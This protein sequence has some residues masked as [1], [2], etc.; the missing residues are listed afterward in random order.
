MRRVIKYYRVRCTLNLVDI[1]LCFNIHIS[2]IIIIIIIIIISSGC[3]KIHLGASGVWA[4]HVSEGPPTC[5]NGKL[6]RFIYSAKSRGCCSGL[7]PLPLDPP[8]MMTVMV[9]V[10]TEYNSS[11]VMNGQSSS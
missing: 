3:R 5:S 9:V 10:E 8:L 7:R 11:I 4:I 1:V 6:G 2:A